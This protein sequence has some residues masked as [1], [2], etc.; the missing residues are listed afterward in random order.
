MSL[1]CIIVDYL[2]IGIPTIA[3]DI[4]NDYLMRTLRSLTTNQN[5]YGNKS[6]ILIVV[7]LGDA[8]ENKRTQLATEIKDKY[9]L[10]INDGILD[11]I[12]VHPRNYYPSFDNLKQRFGDSEMRVRWRSK[13]IIDFSFL[14]CYCY[15]LGK[16]HLQLED[17]VIA[18]PYY[19]LKLKDFIEGYEAKEQWFTLDASVM[20]YIGKVHHNYDLNEIASFYYIFF[21]EMPVDWMEYNWREIKGQVNRWRFR[22]ASLFQHIGLISSLKNKKMPSTEPYFDKHSQ[23]FLGLNPPATLYTDLIEQKNTKLNSAYGQGGGYFW[24]T[25]HHRA[26]CFIKVTFNNNVQVRR[27]AVETGGNFAVND[28]IHRGSLKIGILDPKTNH[29]NSYQVVSLASFLLGTLDIKFAAGQEVKCLRI[30]IE[31]QNEWIF[32]REIN[33]WSVKG[34]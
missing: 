15:G 32:I 1:A 11:I 8:Q 24:G 7:Q 26:K 34:N 6:D 19:Y 14:S 22:A 13:Q 23:K 27:V 12:Q 21:D 9:P 33:V 2:T 30:D 5:L 28:T 17:D 10:L 16:Y 4:G 18:S 29:C 31:R 20:G 25:C 3:R